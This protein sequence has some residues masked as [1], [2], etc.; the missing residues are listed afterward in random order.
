MNQTQTLFNIQTILNSL[1]NDIR[2]NQPTK[3][4]VMSLILE[5]KVVIISKSDKIIISNN[6]LI[7][8]DNCKT[9][10][11]EMTINDQLISNELVIKFKKIPIKDPNK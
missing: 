9:I 1:F 11:T 6:L 10:F 3:Q 7:R 2:N 5:I 8:V 4:C